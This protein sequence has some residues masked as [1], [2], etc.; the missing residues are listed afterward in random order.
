M[1]GRSIELPAGWTAGEF[2]T[3]LSRY[4]FANARYGDGKPASKADILAN[5]QPMVEFEDD[6][7]TVHYRFENAR[8]RALTNPGGG[9][10]IVPVGRT[11]K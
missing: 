4:D 10:Y 8:G 3:R 1:G 7:G 6:A 5:Y 9:V 2:D 11:P